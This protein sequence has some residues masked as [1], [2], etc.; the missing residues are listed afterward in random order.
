[1]GLQTP[2]TNRR[3]IKTNAFTSPLLVIP[4]EIRNNILTNAFGNRL[5]HIDI[6]TQA[7]SHPQGVFLKHYF[8]QSDMTEFEIRDEAREGT[9][10]VPEGDTKEYYI[11]PNR[12]RHAHCFPDHGDSQSRLDLNI[13]GASRQLYEEGNHILWTTNTFSFT[14]S[15]TLRLFFGSLNAAQKRKLTRLHIAADMKNSEWEGHTMTDSFKWEMAIKLNLGFLKNLT[16]VHLTLELQD[17]ASPSSAALAR[18]QFGIYRDDDIRDLKEDPEIQLWWLKYRTR[19][20]LSLR[21]LPSIKTATMVISDD[22]SF[23]RRFPDADRW[24]AAA[25]NEFADAYEA[26]LLDSD[27]ART[28]KAEEKAV[29]ERNRCRIAAEDKRYLCD[30]KERL[31]SL[32]SSIE[33]IRRDAT[34]G[35][36]SPEEIIITEDM[37]RGRKA[38]RDEM[39]A[40]ATR[41]ENLSL[42]IWGN[43]KNKRRRKTVGNVSRPLTGPLTFGHMDPIFLGYG[44]SS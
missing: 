41:L 29:T 3:R 38:L 14:Q 40:R 5:I 33:Y 18:Q 13:L 20:F 39:V 23:Y 6:K 22:V 21:T 30:A 36:A 37:V 24:T 2:D 32:R 34:N 7:Y 1:M 10:E 8:C 27:S 43:D 12:T 28:I 16:T 15:Q 11:T 35:V 4:A 31:L 25:K 26:A 17:D 19:A 42:D 9:A 44:P